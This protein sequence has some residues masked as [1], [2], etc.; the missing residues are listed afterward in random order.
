MD[1]TR[2]LVDTGKVGAALALLSV[3]ALALSLALGARSRSRAGAALRRGALLSGA[4][5]LVWP[6]WLVYNAIENRF[7]LDSVAA[8]LLN[9]ALF[10]I[11]GTAGG[12]LM[13]RLWPVSDVTVNR[14]DA[15]SAE[16]TR[17][18]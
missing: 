8:L 18:V 3:L 13:R 6:L 4:V 5:V 7:G 12:L 10:A 9:L 14:V 16:R 2:E 15:E 1:D 17:E 11:I